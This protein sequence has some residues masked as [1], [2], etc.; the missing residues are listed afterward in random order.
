MSIKQKF[1]R[2]QVQNR[3]GNIKLSWLLTIKLFEE[4]GIPIVIQVAGLE[5][6]EEYSK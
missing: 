3:E 6:W 4:N 5:C 2:F 1:I